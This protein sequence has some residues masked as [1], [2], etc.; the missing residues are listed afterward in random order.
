MAGV[1]IRQRQ[2]LAGF[3]HGVAL[4]VARKARAAAQRAPAP[5][6][7]LP[8]SPDPHPEPLDA[9]TA[10]EL[11]EVLHEEVARLPERYRLPVVLCCLEGRTQ[12]E[13]ARQFAEK[14][15]LKH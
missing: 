7:V 14:A 4:R 8:E 11:L 15:G 1:S 3:L 5:R 10:R 6:S 13:A 2:S 9:L 12:E